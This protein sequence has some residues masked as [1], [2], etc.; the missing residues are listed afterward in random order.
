MTARTTADEE[1]IEATKAP[2]LD[3][4][5]ELRK[6]LVISLIAFAICFAL[7]FGFAKYIY[8]FLTEP[9]AHALAGQPN[10]HL[11]YTALYETFF[12]YV[13]LGMFAGLCLSFPLVASQLWMFIAPGLYRHERRAFLPFL[14]ASPVLFVMGAAFVYYVMLPFAI[15]FF[16]GYETPGGHG[17]LGIELQAKVSEYLDFVTTLIFAFGLCFQMP[18]LLALLGRVGIVSSA[19]LRSMRRYAILGIVALCAVVTPPD[20][21]S[22]TSL[23]LPLIALYEISIWCVRLIENRRAREDAA[24][25]A[26]A[27]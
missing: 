1:A 21:L 17:A 16:V 4:L 10:H 13:K 19:Q 2:L 11:I 3:H 18:V 6:R 9:L 7:C 12:T 20:P 25:A 24:R 14:V 27:A 23:A 26:A 8:A 5:I 15:R 22:M